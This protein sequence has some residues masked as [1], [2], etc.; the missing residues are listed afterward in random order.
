M[1]FFKTI[2]GVITNY[3]TTDL[4][5]LILR[6]GGKVFKFERINF[7]NFFKK[8][9]KRKKCHDSFHFSGIFGIYR[10]CLNTIVTFTLNIPLILFFKIFQ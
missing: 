1:K 5:R 10:K 6:Q 8:H 4:L 9:V 7:K 2:F 3:V